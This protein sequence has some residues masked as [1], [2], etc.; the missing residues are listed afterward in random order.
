MHSLIPQLIATLGGKK[1]CIS[2]FYLE[3]H[4]L[5]SQ[6]L[7]ALS[8]MGRW[9]CGPPQPFRTPRCST[10]QY[11]AVQYSTNSQVPHDIDI[12]HTKEWVVSI[13]MVGAAL[14]PWCASETLSDSI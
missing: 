9:W 7:W 8:P 12:N 1:Q 6:P 3:I 5:P 10:V 13:F 4:N 2:T 14:V 11:S